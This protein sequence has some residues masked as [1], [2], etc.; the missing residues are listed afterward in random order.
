M[1]ADF[2][3]LNSTYTC[4]LQQ[5]TSQHTTLAQANLASRAVQ[6][7]YAAHKCLLPLSLLNT[8]VFIKQSRFAIEKCKTWEVCTQYSTKRNHA[9]V[10][11][12]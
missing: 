12:S 7:D 6:T 9:T 1:R 5:A 2:V 3:T 8:R 4:E 10:I 11:E